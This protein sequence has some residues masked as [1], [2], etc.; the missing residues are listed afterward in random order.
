M[1]EHLAV[2]HPEYASPRNPDGV[3]LPHALW[4]LVEI[5]EEKALNIPASNIPPP[6]TKFGP[7]SPETELLVGSSSGSKRRRGTVGGKSAKR[8]RAN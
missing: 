4:K 7:P 1:E 5:T 6:F 8:C 3:P 2:R